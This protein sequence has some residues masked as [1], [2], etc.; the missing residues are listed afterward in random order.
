MKSPAALRDHIVDALDERKARDIVALDVAGVSDVTDY[1]IVASGTSNRHVKALVDQVLEA[2]RQVS[3]T[4]IGVE[5]REAMEWVLIDMGDVVAH[6]MQAD[7]RS[8]YDLERLW[9]THDLGSSAPT[10]PEAAEEPALGPAAAIDEP[11][12]EP[13]SMVDVERRV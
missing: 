4:P 13:T 11:A 8:F 12:A 1:M 3:V 6:V 5:G 9:G 10:S 7:A 2:A